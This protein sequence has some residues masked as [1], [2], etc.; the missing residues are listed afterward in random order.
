MNIG[1]I[2]QPLVH[3]YGGTLQ[4]FALQAI[5]QRL[6]HKPTTIN[7]GIQNSWVKWA[8]KNLFCIVK[9]RPLSRSPFY[10]SQRDRNFNKF[11][12]R[13]ISRTKPVGL[14]QSKF[15]LKNHFDG[16]IVGSDQVWRK[17]YNPQI[18]FM[19]LDFLPEETKRMA[20]AASIGVD[21]WDYDK[22]LSIT[23][24]E[25]L[26]KFEVVTVRESSAIS[27]LK[28]NV[29]I[30]SY[31]VLDPT[32]LL[33][34]E[35]YEKKLNLSA[36]DPKSE[37][38]AYILDL[39]DAKVSRL[40]SL[41]E[42]TGLQVNIIGSSKMYGNFKISKKEEFPKI[43][44]WL[45]SIRDAKYFVTDSFHGTA[46]AINFHK[47]FVTLQNANRG[48]TRFDSLFTL[49]NLNSRLIE[50]NSEM[51]SVYG[52]LIEPIDWNDIDLKR[53]EL[54]RSSIKYIEKVFNDV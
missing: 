5:L 16:Y 7:W 14:L 43:E 18:Q 6:G 12:N 29:D 30:V 53:D 47:Q 54:I 2:T 52:K 45:E 32:L 11:H 49:F 15:V 23:C 20:Y 25:A 36:R 37:I 27:L 39:D 33:R 13:Y 3:N 50:D 19:F 46:F 40:K 51:M 10:V 35:D 17:S 28:E 22:A 38:V 26:K 8:L 9:S 31:L 1:I 21:A 48:N 42:I 24:K 41:S 44:N 4:A 34:L